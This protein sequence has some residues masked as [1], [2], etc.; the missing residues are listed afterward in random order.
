MHTVQ[1][2]VVT[3]PLP[4]PPDVPSAAAPAP[5]P[6]ALLGKDRPYTTEERAFALGMFA[7]FSV[8]WLVIVVELLL[9]Q[10]V[11]A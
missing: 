10:Y 4:R 7:L 9:A 3:V 11:W 6:P 8:L 5:P 2:A 1:D